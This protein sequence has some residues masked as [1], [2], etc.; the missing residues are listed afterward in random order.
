MTLNTHDAQGV[1]PWDD[2]FAE[3]VDFLGLPANTSAVPLNLVNATVAY[4]VS[5]LVW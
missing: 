1:N 3:L 4:A 5:D 2:K